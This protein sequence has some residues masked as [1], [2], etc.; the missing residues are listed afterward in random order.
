MTTNHQLK[1]V[2]FLSGRE[3]NYP[4][5]QLIINSLK[6]FSKTEVISSQRKDISSGSYT[7]IILQSAK[8]IFVS[9]LKLL[10]NTYQLIFI[11]FFGQLIVLPISIMTK[12]PLVLDFFVSA[13][14]TLVFDRQKIRKTS[15]IAK[16]LYKMEKLG[17]KRAALIYVD[18]QSHRDYFCDLFFIPK[19]KIEVLPVGCDE[20][21]FQPIDVIENLN[22]VL[23]YSTY[24]PLH[25]VDIVIQAA[26]LL[27]NI[28]PIQFKLIGRGMG[29]NR[30]MELARHLNVQNVTFSPPVRLLQL[31]KEIATATICLGGH[32]GDTA[33]ARRVIAGK[34][35]QILAMKKPVIVSDC[36]ANRELLIHTKDA[37][38]CGLSDPKSL[39]EGIKT[40]HENHALRNQIAENGYKTFKSKASFKE[41]GRKFEHQLITHQ[42]H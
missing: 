17:C 21:I 23:Y 6:S 29:L 11:G 39:A 27:E 2:L 4:R 18:T 33:K 1:K 7:R 36:E 3:A 5:N 22:L 37:W 15:I 34:T 14:D 9:I 42:F 41:L 40:L 12:T 28:S 16:L 19:E 30:S 20:D 10:F 31:P 26:K 24:M 35:Y 8:C 25:G 13:Y 32:F 38:F